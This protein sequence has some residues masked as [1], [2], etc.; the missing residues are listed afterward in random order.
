MELPRVDQ[1]QAPYPVEKLLLVYNVES[2]QQKRRFS[3]CKHLSLVSF[4]NSSVFWQLRSEFWHHWIELLVFSLFLQLSL[5]VE[6]LFNNMHPS[7]TIYFN[8][9]IQSYRF[10][11]IIPSGGF[12]YCTG[13]PGG[14][15]LRKSKVIADYQLTILKG[16]NQ[17]F[18]VDMDDIGLKLT[19]LLLATDISQLFISACKLQLRDHTYNMIHQFSRNQFSSHLQIISN[20]TPASD[21]YGRN[22]CLD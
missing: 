22:G 20:G 19:K 8:S 17:Q 15:M 14:L 7:I 6:L 1:P 16:N 2:C 11:C 4:V 13:L 18:S 10:L 3:S 21:W 5:I 12:T 9:P